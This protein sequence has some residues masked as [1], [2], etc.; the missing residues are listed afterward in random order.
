MEGTQGSSALLYLALAAPA[1]AARVRALALPLGAAAAAVPPPSAGSL[2]SA[3]GAAAAPSQHA[4]CVPAA[5]ALPSP[6][7][8]LPSS[9]RRATGDARKRRSAGRQLASNCFAVPN[10][11]PLAATAASP[12]HLLHCWR[13]QLN[14]THSRLNQVM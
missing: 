9:L 8:A 12:A 13:H 10:S 5:A 2:P 3:A 6:G 4:G 7:G 11:R 14:I 1:A